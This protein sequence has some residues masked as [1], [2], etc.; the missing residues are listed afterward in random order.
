M[1]FGR[2]VGATLRVGGGWEEARG[3]PAGVTVWVVEPGGGSGVDGGGRRVGVRF[4]W[5]R[6][7][8]RQRLLCLVA[9]RVSPSLLSRSLWR[10][11]ETPGLS[12]STSVRSVGT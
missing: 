4:E 11:H 3:R 6:W 10:L 2:G 7:L 8:T 5:W 1:F 12:S 9:G